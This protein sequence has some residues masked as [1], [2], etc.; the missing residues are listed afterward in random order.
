MD[1]LK[2]NREKI[3]IIAGIL[4]VAA[5]CCIFFVLS[6]DKNLAKAKPISATAPS[7]QDRLNDGDK[8]KS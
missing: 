2:T 8:T 5:I 6:V 3:T 4:V 1:F 7:F